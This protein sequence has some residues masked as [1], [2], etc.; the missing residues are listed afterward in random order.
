LLG[1]VTSLIHHR[2]IVRIA[3]PPVFLLLFSIWF[4]V[5]FR[6]EGGELILGVVYG[7]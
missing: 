6:G 1:D 2:R 3:G 5:G 4:R 7:I